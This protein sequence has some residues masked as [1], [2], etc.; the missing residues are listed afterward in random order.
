MKTEVPGS[1]LHEKN[2]LEPGTSVIGSAGCPYRRIRYRI[3]KY[4]PNT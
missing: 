1:G 4:P 2:R 3:M